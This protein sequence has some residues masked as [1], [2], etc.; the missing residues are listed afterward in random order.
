MA[1]V[2]V[3]VS[4]TSMPRAART[5]TKGKGV[6]SLPG[7]PSMRSRSSPANTN[8][9][10]MPIVQRMLRGTFFRTFRDIGKSFQEVKGWQAGRPRHRPSDRRH[11]T[12][13]SIWVKCYI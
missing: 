7:R 13:D 10:M 1:P 2:K 12:P 6:T 5:V 8:K 9:V 11:R 4:A 3:T